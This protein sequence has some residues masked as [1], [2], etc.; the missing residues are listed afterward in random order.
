VQIYNFTNFKDFMNSR[1]APIFHS[2]QFQKELD[3]FID[4]ALHEDVG[5]RDHTSFACISAK[6]KA[7]GR[8]LVKTDGIIAGIEVAKRIFKKL[9]KK[10]TIDTFFNDG[11]EVSKGDIAFMVDGNARMLHTGER[12][13]LNVM[14]RMSGVATMAHHLTQLCKGT[15][16]K[17]IDTRKTTPG[18]RLLEKWAVVIGG[19]TNHRWGLYDMIL[20]KDNHVHCSSGIKNAI[21][22]AQHYLIKENRKLDIEIEVGNFTELK[23]VLEVGGIQRILI[24]NFSPADM[25]KAVKMVGGK[26]RT[27]ASGGITESNIR[28]YALT[29]VDFISV[30][31]LTHSVKSLDLSL[32]IYPLE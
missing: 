26:Y 18:M 4:M 13:A 11:D 6:A 14:Q 5:E 31:A 17:V 21:K 32:K 25:A 7:E 8:L 9:D 28:K 23:E 16:A 12:L 27:E 29:G 20:I 24:D 15:K 3:D 2:K 19:A 10:L 22:N 1:T 30:G